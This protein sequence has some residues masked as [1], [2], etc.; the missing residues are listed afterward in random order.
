MPFSRFANARNTLLSVILASSA[1]AAVLIP[2]AAHATLLSDL[3]AGGSISAFELDFSNW[4]FGSSTGGP[5]PS[6]IDVTALLDDPDNPGL[7]FTGNGQLESLPGNT[8]VTLDF[9][10][11]VSS[12]GRDIIGNS[13]TIT[14]LVVGGNHTASIDEQVRAGISVLGTLKAGST[15]IGSPLPLSDSQAFTPRTAL[16][17]SKDILL[18]IEGSA[19]DEARL[20]SFTQRFALQPS[21]VPAPDSLALSL[22]G[23][24]GLLRWRQH[25]TV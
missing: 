4:S 23:I 2:G 8:L 16:Q 21:Q 20:N 10:F 19:G 7:L 9:V 15:N 22:I 17:I 13:L 24:V 5:D 18:E 3:F 6:Q 1:C 11:D 14:D 25:R 12:N